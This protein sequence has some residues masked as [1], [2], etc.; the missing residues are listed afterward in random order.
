MVL[1]RCISFCCLFFLSCS[2][3]NLVRVDHIPFL[4]NPIQP[5]SE[6]EFFLFMLII[7]LY[8]A[9]RSDFSDAIIPRSL[10]IEVRSIS[11][12]SSHETRTLLIHL[13]SVVLKSLLWKTLSLN[14][15]EIAKAKSYTF[16]IGPSLQ[17]NLFS[18]KIMKLQSSNSYLIWITKL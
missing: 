3:Q 7:S 4:L 16:E 17:S 12:C 8:F 5:V 14:I 18:I 2:Y 6:F 10:L 13:L 15:Q 11:L 1:S 9:F